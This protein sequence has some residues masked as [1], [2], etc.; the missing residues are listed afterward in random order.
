MKPEALIV[1][2]STVTKNDK[3]NNTLPYYMRRTQV[4]NK[5]YSEYSWTR[6]DT[7][8]EGGLEKGIILHL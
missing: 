3:R 6:C 7:V 1:L 8:E 5:Y 4:I 2:C